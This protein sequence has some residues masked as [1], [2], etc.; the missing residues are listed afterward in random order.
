MHFLKTLGF[1]LTENDG[2]F[3]LSV[4]NPIVITPDKLIK[5]K[6]L[7]CKTDIFDLKKWLDY[8]KNNDLLFILPH[9]IDDYTIEKIIIWLKNNRSTYD[10]YQYSISKN[11]YNSIRKYYCIASYSEDRYHSQNKSLKK[12]NRC[13][14]FCGKTKEDGALFSGNAHA[15]SEFL[16]NKK[17]FQYDECNECNNK[18]SL[19][20]NDIAIYFEP[21]RMMFNV[22]G[23]TSLKGSGS[24]I[25]GKS[26]I[27][28]QLFNN[29]IKKDGD[30][31]YIN[32][33]SSRAIILQNVY[34]SFVSYFIAL[35]GHHIQDNDLRILR[36]WLFSVPQAQKLP[37]V[38][39]K[40]FPKQHAKSP[41]VICY[42]R[43]TDNCLLPKYIFEFHF[44]F[45]VYIIIIPLLDDSCLFADKNDYR[46]L[47]SIMSHWQDIDSWIFIDFSSCQKEKIHY[48]WS[49]IK[50]Q[51]TEK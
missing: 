27:I 26:G 44:L 3:G 7:L 33:D 22:N 4:N 23:K 13:C 42:S 48:Y 8:R 1:I 16:G 25:K 24:Y 29:Q 21:I 41:N 36:D 28:F 15:V 39:A 11:L 18:L 19:I 12:D 20:E 51:Q 9:K 35:H 10:E 46:Q 5:L 31:F 17:L 2:K 49:F 37:L 6:K 43:Q 40:I 50:N 30:R 34:K 45:W 14:L 38:A 32:F 47:W